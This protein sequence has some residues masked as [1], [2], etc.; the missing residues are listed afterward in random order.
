ME[1]IPRRHGGKLNSWGGM[2]CGRRKRMHMTGLLQMI[3]ESKLS[4]FLLSHTRSEVGKEVDTIY[5]LNFY[6]VGL[7]DQLI[8][9][10]VR[11]IS[12]REK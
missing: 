4:T 9:Y 12:L 1:A 11:S 7:L 2:H 8:F 10:N 5:D 3:I 6:K